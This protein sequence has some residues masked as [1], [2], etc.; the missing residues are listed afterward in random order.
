MASFTRKS[1]SSGAKGVGVN[2]GGWSWRKKRESAPAEEPRAS[3]AF[4][5]GAEPTDPGERMTAQLLTSEFMQPTWQY[6]GG[7]TAG[8]AAPRADLDDDDVSPRVPVSPALANAAARR[9]AGRGRESA[10]VSVLELPPPDPT[11]PM[12]PLPQERQEELSRAFDARLSGTWNPPGGA[13][14]VPRKQ[15]QRE[16]ARAAHE[17]SKEDA[18][19]RGR[20]AAAA[21]AAAKRH[22]ALPRNARAAPRAPAAGLVGI[23]ASRPRDVGADALSSD[24]EEDDDDVDVNDATCKEIYEAVDVVC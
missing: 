19:A 13:E 23:N 18:P 10:L 22:A 1:S 17:D 16:R 9:R 8:G 14:S 7:N 2:C 15:P 20:G 3:A 5:A 24:E 6:S 12:A 11:A 21:A 4:P